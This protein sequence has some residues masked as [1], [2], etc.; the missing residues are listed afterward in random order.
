MQVDGQLCVLEL[1]RKIDRSVLLDPENGER[2]LNSSTD[3]REKRY[4]DPLTGAYNRTYYCLLY[5]ALPSERTI[6]Q[7]APAAGRN[8]RP[9]G[10]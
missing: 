9:Q 3:E 2:L 4:R 8:V 10:P 1:T 5:T 6:S 7:A